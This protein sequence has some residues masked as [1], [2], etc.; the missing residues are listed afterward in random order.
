MLMYFVL[1]QILLYLHG[2]LVLTGVGV[3]STC[4]YHQNVLAVPTSVNCLSLLSA[5]SK[6]ETLNSKANTSIMVKQCIYL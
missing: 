6:M 1:I 5:D 3:V 2:L 4:G